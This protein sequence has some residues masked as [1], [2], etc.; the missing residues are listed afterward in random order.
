MSFAAAH[1]WKRTRRTC[2]SCFDRKARFSVR[3]SVRADRNHTLCFECYRSERERQRALRL[4]ELPA[5]PLLTEALTTAAPGGSLS[6]REVAHR[7]AM[8]AQMEQNA[9]WQAGRR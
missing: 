9:I 2:Q 1:E 3:R 7:Q 5:A 8:L 4:S 6:D